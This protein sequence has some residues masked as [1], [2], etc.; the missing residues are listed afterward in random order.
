VEYALV[1]ISRLFSVIKF[2]RFVVN[3]E[4]QAKKQQNLLT[5]SS[6][7]DF[8]NECFLFLWMFEPKP[9]F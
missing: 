1:T 4:N 7:I 2:L 3:K 9:P 6:K 5:D 8:M